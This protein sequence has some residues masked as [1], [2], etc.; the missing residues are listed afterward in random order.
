MRWITSSRLEEW[1]GLP[2]YRGDLPAIVGDLIRASCPDISAFRF[3][4]GD[5]GQVRG[6]DG[7]LETTWGGN[8]VPEGNSYWEFGTE[9]TYQRKGSQEFERCSDLVSEDVRKDATFVFVSPW[10]WDSS[11][12][13][14]KIEDWEE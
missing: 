3:P 8:N 5:K 1:A 7:H 13:D 9:E 11:K 14:N 12:A 2:S 10:T 4:S 6:F